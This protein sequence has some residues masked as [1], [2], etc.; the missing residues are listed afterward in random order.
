MLKAAFIFLALVIIGYLSAVFFNPDLNRQMSA[1]LPSFI[2]DRAKNIFGFSDNQNGAE[3]TNPFAF[4]NVENGSGGADEKNEKE[5]GAKKH[6][7]APLYLPVKEK[8]ESLPEVAAK[9]G[10]A[11]A[12]AKNFIFQKAQSLPEA[13][14]EGISA[15]KEKAEEKIVEKTIKRLVEGLDEKNKESLQKII[16]APAP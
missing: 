15:V 11:A 13:A 6:F 7:Y 4:F 3:K 16:C 9:A 14:S 5:S 8:L 12:E 10:Q 2:V 1:L